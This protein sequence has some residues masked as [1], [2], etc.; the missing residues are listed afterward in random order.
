MNTNIQTQ[1]AATRGILNKLA[2]NGFIINQVIPLNH[3]RYMMAKTDRKTILIMYKREPFYNFG[4]NFRHKG[5]KGVGD[6]VNK[7]DLQLAIQSKVNEIYTV[8]PN[9][10]VYSISIQNILEKGEKWTNKEGKE[11][12][13]FSIHEYRREFEL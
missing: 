9:G 4:R 11:V 7:K 2:V 5:Y 13:S 3:S 12:Y 8:F 6:S 1:E 10:Y